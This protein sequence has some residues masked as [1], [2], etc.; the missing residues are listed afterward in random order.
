M[1]L[2]SITKAGNVLPEF[3]EQRLMP[4]A[5]PAVKFLIGAALPFAV[6]KANAMLASTVSAL[7]NAI[8]A[9]EAKA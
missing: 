7:Q 8:G 4:S 9:L 5:P 6:R 2:I 1:S 3:A